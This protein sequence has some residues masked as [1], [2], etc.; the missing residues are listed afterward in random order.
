MG[1]HLNA[2]TWV[3]DNFEGTRAFYSFFVAHLK[4]FLLQSCSVIETFVLHELF[5]GQANFQNLATETSTP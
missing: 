3:W 2:I 4:L 1:I 5:R